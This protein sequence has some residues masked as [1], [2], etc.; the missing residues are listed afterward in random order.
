VH[1]KMP[2]SSEHTQHGLGTG[3][4]GQIAQNLGEELETI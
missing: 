2:M 4:C 3:S 1:L